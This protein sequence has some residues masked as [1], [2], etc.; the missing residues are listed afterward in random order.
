MQAAG[1][2]WWTYDAG[3][4]F[5]PANQYQDQGYI[6]RLLR[7]VETAVYLPLMRVH[8]YMSNTEPWNYGEEAQQILRQCLEERYRL[9]PYIY[10]NA[11]DVMWEGSTLMR[12]LVFDFAYDEEAMKVQREYMFGRALL[13]CPIT[14]SGVTEWRAYLPAWAPGWYDF[15]TGKHYKG[16]QQVIVGVDKASIPVFV[17]AGA[18]LPYGIQRQHTNDNLQAPLD[19]RVY[20]GADADFSLYEDDGISN[21]HEKGQCSRIDFTWDDVAKTLTIGKRKGSFDGMP[22]KRTFRICLQ[23]KVI[24]EVNYKGKKVTVRL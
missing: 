3:G 19:I 24:Q 4:F 10:S 2:P 15:R 16:G 11:A 23:D 20:P 6:E 21:D 17:K 12:P 13:V 1:L 14:D 22:R 5:R 9:L 8:G 18:I 7:W